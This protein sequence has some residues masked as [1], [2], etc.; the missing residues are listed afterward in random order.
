MKDG[1][2]DEDVLNRYAVQGN[3]CPLGQFTEKS[4]QMGPLGLVNTYSKGDNDPIDYVLEEMW[5][6]LA[7]CENVA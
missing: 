6:C 2:A 3:I 4:R 1:G 5:E 7:I